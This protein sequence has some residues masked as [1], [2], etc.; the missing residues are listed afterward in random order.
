M[1]ISGAFILYN[2]GPSRDA[3]ILV[4]V[5][6]LAIPGAAT[7]AI[8]RYRLWDIDL[9]INRTLVYVPLTGL[10]A[11]LYT[12]AVAALQRA[13]LAITGE[14]SDAPIILSALVL[15][16]LF[17]PI[18][19]RLQVLVDARFKGDA[20]PTGRLVAFANE[21]RADYRLVD[22]NRL[23]RRI[24]DLVGA[25]TGATVVRLE[26]HAHP[27]SG[28][29]VTFG[30]AP[31][32]AAVVIDLEA[33]ERAIGR[34]EVGPRASGRPYRPADVDAMQAAAAAVAEAVDDLAHT[35]AGGQLKASHPT[36]DDPPGYPRAEWTTPS[37]SSTSSA[38]RRSSG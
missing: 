11:G 34:L 5:G 24:V 23:G 31:D 7:V 10:L 8:L 12:I 38:T 37:R 1:L 19:N 36:R 30:H 28:K 14:D 20:D 13:F 16:S 21:V 32:Q 2:F 18:K 26:L 33:P 4:T 17:T 15:A 22:P 35:A 6:F 27:R 9:I 3:E 25:A 29:P